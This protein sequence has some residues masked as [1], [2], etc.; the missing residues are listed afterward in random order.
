MTCKEAIGQIHEFLD[1]ELAHENYIKTKQ[2]IETCQKCCEKFEF[3]QALKKT[4]KDRFPLYKSPQHLLQ[5]IVGQWAELN[6]DSDHSKPVAVESKGGFL[7]DIL[8]FLTLKPAYVTMTILLPMTIISL[9]VYVTFFRASE[10]PSIVKVAVE[11]HDSFVNNNINLDLVSSDSNEI[12]RHFENLKR[13]NLA[14]DLPECNG[15]EMELL[16]CKKSILDGKNSAY[17]GLR[18]NQ[19]KISFEIVNGSGVNIDKME[20]EFYNGRLYYFCK[21]KG[22]NVVLWK[23]GNTLYS[24]TS[25]MNIKDLMRVASKS[26]RSYNNK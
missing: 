9:V 4:I 8:D 10:F 16:G 25:T 22:Y 15:R 21:H 12:R 17:V 5:N 18:G 23:Q 6:R 11:R 3:E 2:H 13:S 19:N 14:I 1:K 24:M 7:R 26:K 20:Q